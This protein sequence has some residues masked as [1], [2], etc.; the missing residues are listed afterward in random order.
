MARDSGYLRVEGEGKGGRNGGPG[1]CMTACLSLMPSSV[2]LS[3]AGEKENPTKMFPYKLAYH[4][5]EY[6]DLQC[7]VI[8]N[9]IQPFTGRYEIGG[10]VHNVATRCT[11][12]PLEG[13]GHVYA[14]G[15]V[16][17]LPMFKMECDGEGSRRI[18]GEEDAV[19][20]L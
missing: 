6:R 11:L 20:R 5:S 10:Q 15:A 9:P 1:S 19:P 4:L 13:Y 3:E 14:E 18:L 16:Q 8:D 12:W 2:P 17:T 7:S